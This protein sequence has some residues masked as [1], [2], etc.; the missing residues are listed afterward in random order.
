MSH[1]LFI[2]D[3]H[4]CASRPLVNDAF[5]RFMRD[6]APKAE[7]LYILGDLFEY[8]IGDDDMSEG[9]NAEVVAALR[10]LSDGGTR[11]WFMH[12]NRDFLIGE[13]FAEAAG[14]QLLPDPTLVELY[15]K[16]VLLMHGD[17]LCTDDVDYQRFRAMVRD[18]A[19]QAAF[20]A[21][22]LPERRREVEEMRRQSEASKREK[23]MAIMDVSQS[24]EET[25]RIF[26]YPPLLIHGHTHRPA[27]HEVSANGH[28]CA[29]RVLSDWHADGRTVVAMYHAD[30]LESEICF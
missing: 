11:V 8:W 6:D 24:A 20:L 23:P 2:S 28:V 15:G 4:L 14:L 22:P 13:R 12:G 26:A 18:P 10:T 19:W 1:T 7:S 17:T 3:L 21:R 25:L 30:N 16:R 29:R 5:F 27:R 9:L